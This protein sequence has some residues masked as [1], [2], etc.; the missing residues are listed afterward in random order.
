MKVNKSI[1][2]ASKCTYF[3]SNPSNISIIE[4]LIE[5]NINIFLII[6]N[7]V[8]PYLFKSKI[9]YI[10]HEFDYDFFKFQLIFK[11]IKSI[12]LNFTSIRFI[13]NQ[14][15]DILEVLNDNLKKL[16][17]LNLIKYKSNEIDIAV[18]DDTPVLIFDTL[19]KFIQFNNKIFIS[20][21]IW[22]PQ[23]LSGNSLKIFN[24]AKESFKL[25]NKI[26]VQDCAR[27]KILL[28]TKD[29]AHKDFNVN[30]L[31]VAYNYSCSTEDK[32]FQG[33]ILT[34]GSLDLYTG[35]DQL[36]RVIKSDAFLNQFTFNFQ[37]HRINT[38]NPLI[39]SLLEDS[40]TKNVVVEKNNFIN[41]KH[42]LKYISSFD[43]GISLYFP[44][45]HDDISIELGD[46]LSEIG[47]S[48]GK[49]AAYLACGLPVVFSYS[50]LLHELNK[51]YEF[52]IMI[53]KVSDL[54]N[55][56]NEIQNK[57]KI[58]SQNALNFYRS[59]LKPYKFLKK[60]FSA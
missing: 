31:P 49:M 23:E 33:K 2:I 24:L 9:S 26:I 18:I 47:L 54:G 6:P 59:E 25:F 15:K 30:Y 10:N 11:K 19:N 35:V 45:Q 44:H 22:F 41:Y 37:T 40:S 39:L 20:Y 55:A 5:R 42:Y 34:S 16:I 8:Y 17:F 3:F 48:S 14:F 36:L 38:T 53:N 58:Y 60:I 46:N 29:V 13:I 32:I 27:E 7:Q 51:K 4:Y 1:L 57:Y 21:E 56:I 43:I 12:T 50:N 52:G 28:N